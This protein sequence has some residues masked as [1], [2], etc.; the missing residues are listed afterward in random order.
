[1]ADKQ[2]I[3]AEVHA[4]EWQ[5]HHSDWTNGLTLGFAGNNFDEFKKV[6]NNM[7][8]ARVDAAGDAYQQVA[9][10][11]KT[12]LETIYNQAKVLRDH[13]GGEAADQQMQQMQ[14]LYDQAFEIHRVSTQTAGALKAHAKMQA[15]WQQV[16]QNDPDWNS[17]GD[18]WFGDTHVG[19]EMMNALND[20]TVASNNNF[21]PQIQSDMPQSSLADYDPSKMPGGPGN[22][23][24]G[25]GHMPGGG[26]MPGAGH[27]PGGGGMPG[28]GHLPGAGDGTGNL[29][30]GGHLPGSGNDLSGSGHL[31]GGG[32]LPGAG[33]LP[34][35]S[36]T[37]LAGFDPTSGLGSGGFPG[38]GGMG[39]DPLGGAGSLGA[40]SGPG[41]L[42]AGG[43]GA[44]GLT[45][46][47]LG[48]GAGAAG[49][50]MNAAGRAGMGPGMMPMHPG[51]Q[52]QGDKERERHTNLTED[53]D[54]WGAQEGGPG[55][56][57]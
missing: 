47:G 36:G 18:Y 8:P 44:G 38:G 40:G 1:M 34:A 20:Q 29:P 32:S 53:E 15:S 52:G 3:K 57:G 21:P 16:V 43:L 25:G 33:H 14:K 35:G 55:L 6:I 9:N 42:G 56:I 19:T 41:G 46:G 26:G 5:Q 48:G 11:M 31:P 49:A 22:I 27:L 54:V 4:D 39:G 51:G 30:G 12:T 7:Q 13:W 10:R 17:F 28:A 24:G 37:H 23:P 50:G 2:D 45:G